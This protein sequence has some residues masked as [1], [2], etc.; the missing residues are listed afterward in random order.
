MADAAALL[1]LLNAAGAA[2]DCDHGKARMY[3][4]R[5]TALLLAEQ[6]GSRVLPSIRPGGMPRWQA[7]RVAAYIE[8]HCGESIRS[9][10]L[11][12]LTPL[13]PGHFFRTFKV[14]FGEA[15]FAYIAR[16][17]IERAQELMVTT[18]VPLAQ[19]A[20]AC[21]LCDQSHLTRLF[22]RIVGVSPKAWRRE[23][24]CRLPG[25]AGGPAIL[26][27]QTKF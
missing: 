13:S 5:A 22:R 21:G 15:P 25:R 20:L 6:S 19:I 2:V 12:A 1:D 18:N 23:Y 10:D 16:R 14:T 24:A 26:Q 11:V 27:S 17:R 7:K 8:E 4:E 9:G 3:L